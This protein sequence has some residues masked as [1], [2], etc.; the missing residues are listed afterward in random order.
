MCL[1]GT[2]EA[3]YIC[4]PIPVFSIAQW[5]RNYQS[6]FHRSGHW[7]LRSRNLLEY[8]PLIGG[9]KNTEIYKSL[10]FVCSTSPPVLC[11][12][13]GYDSGS[14]TTVRCSSACFL[15]PAYPSWFAA[16]PLPK[17]QPALC[18][19]WP[20]SPPLQ[21]NLRVIQF[22][23]WRWLNSLEMWFHSSFLET[24]RLAIVISH[25]GKFLERN[26]QAKRFHFRVLMISLYL[27]GFCEA[28]MR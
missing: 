18:V 21:L 26:W 6:H 8:M 20:S 1:L 12:D 23:Y 11:G 5:N 3:I 17:A 25:L 16:W 14:V 9:Q 13:L 15:V 10:R 22:Q 4:H 28:P 7:T 24:D 2:W 27:M 19:Q